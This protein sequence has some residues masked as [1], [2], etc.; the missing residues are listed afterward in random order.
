MARKVW[1]VRE[2]GNNQIKRLFTSRKKA[3]E[4][5]SRLMQLHKV[6]QFEWRKTED[7]TGAAVMEFVY[8][9]DGVNIRSMIIADELVY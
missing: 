4:H 8:I 2:M 5:V 7:I 6:T 3:Q 9:F 1:A